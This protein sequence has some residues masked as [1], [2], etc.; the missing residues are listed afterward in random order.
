VTGRGGGWLIGQ[1]SRVKLLEVRGA[2]LG[3]ETKRKL[4]NAGRTAKQ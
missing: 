2:K 3:G 1:E 4:R